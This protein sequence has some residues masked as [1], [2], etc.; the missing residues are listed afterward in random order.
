MFVNKL[1]SG[2]LPEVG[3]W[4]WCVYVCILQP[5]KN[6]KIQIKKTKHSP[7]EGE[8]NR[9]TCMRSASASASPQ[10]ELRQHHVSPST[11]RALKAC[12]RLW[13]I[14]RSPVSIQGGSGAVTTAEQER[15]E[16]SNNPKISPI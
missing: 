13:A 3:W 15:D 14:Q 2:F 10:V 1:N 5:K 11:E 4:W 6:E 7:R 16:K 9:K 8:R 12:L